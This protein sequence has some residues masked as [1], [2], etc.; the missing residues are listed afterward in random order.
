MAAGLR[1]WLIMH[2]C[3]MPV[4]LSISDMMM[5]QM[6]GG[7]C[8]ALH[9]HQVKLNTNPEFYHALVDRQELPKAT[10][11]TPHHQLLLQIHLQH[12]PQQ[13]RKGVMRA[14]TESGNVAR[15]PYLICVSRT[16]MP[17]PTRRKNLGEFLNSTTRR[18]RTS[19]FGPVW[20]YGRNLHLWYIWLME[21]QDT[22]P[23][24]PSG[25]WPSTWQARG[26]KDIPRWCTM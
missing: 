23:G 2:Y 8:V 7:T 4:A 25:G 15:L 9:S 6:S 17:D 3:A 14:A 20:N 24:M 1:F 10:L 12:H 18:R 11:P 5:W 13:L 16:Q 19:T 21:L 26:T 22:R